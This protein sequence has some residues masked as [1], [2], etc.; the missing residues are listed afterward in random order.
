MLTLESIAEETCPAEV[1]RKKRPPWWLHILLLVLIATSI[2][3][4]SIFGLC[5]TKLVS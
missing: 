3:G 2:A 5:Y 1:L 4:A